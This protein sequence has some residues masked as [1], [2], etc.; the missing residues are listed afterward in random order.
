MNLK[1]I[2][3]QSKQLIHTNNSVHPTGTPATTFLEPA[4]ETNLYVQFVYVPQTIFN[5]TRGQV[6]G[7]MNA[8]LINANKQV[9]NKQL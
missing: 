1:Y 9:N 6:I 3:D 5:H 7:S 8:D 2:L 4:G